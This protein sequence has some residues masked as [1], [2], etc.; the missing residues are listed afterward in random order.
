VLK[1]GAVGFCE[2]KVFKL[3]PSCVYKHNGLGVIRTS[4]FASKSVALLITVM[5]R[6]AEFCKLVDCVCCVSPVQADGTNPNISRKR[7][8][9]VKYSIGRKSVYDDYFGKA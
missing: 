5:F 8:I 7:T 2:L 9:L 3:G 4:Y 6:N 1:E